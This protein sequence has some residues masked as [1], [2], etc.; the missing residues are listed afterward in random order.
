MTCGFGQAS[1]VPEACYVLVVSNNQAD[2]GGTG[3]KSWTSQVGKDGRKR[4]TKARN[5]RK[6]VEPEGR[7]YAGVM[8]RES[9]GEEA[10]H[11]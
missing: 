3:Q 6:G 1:P 8:I 9:E 2:K 7:R 4:G 11:T 10:V 5:G